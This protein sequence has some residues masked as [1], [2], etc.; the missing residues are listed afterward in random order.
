MRKYLITI[1]F[2]V[3][4]SV[5][6]IGISLGA[7]AKQSYIKAVIT[8]NESGKLFS[9]NLLY[10]VKNIPLDENGNKQDSKLW[11]EESYYTIAREVYEE[12]SITEITIPIKIFNYL[13]EDKTLVNNLDIAYTLKIKIL[14]ERSIENY[15]FRI[16]NEETVPI[17]TKEFTVN[18][19]QLLKG[20]IA[21]ENTYYITIP[22]SDVGKVSFIVEADRAKDSTGRYG[23]DL[24]CLASRVTPTLD[25]SVQSSSF[26]RSGFVNSDKDPASMVAYS[27]NLV[28]DGAPTA[29][30]ITWDSNYLEIDPT[31]TSKYD[32]T[33]N[34]NT[35]TINMSAGTIQIQFYKV[36]TPPSF[37]NLINLT[38]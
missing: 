30:S 15:K 3:L 16:N 26:E 33:I 36:A 17:T 2:L 35:T 1:L 19:T 29:V 7:Y 14:G 4:V 38:Y 9:S 25:A 11:T 18:N 24:A 6:G 21:N 32:A 27:Y 34:G 5:A 22:K 13:K 8:T 23:T 10:G 20:R 37:E 31:F 12:P 28:L